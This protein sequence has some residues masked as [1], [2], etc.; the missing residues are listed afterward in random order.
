[1]HEKGFEIVIFSLDSSCDYQLVRK[2]LV[3]SRLKFDAFVSFKPECD[4]VIN[5]KTVELNGWEGILETL[6]R[7][8]KD[9]QKG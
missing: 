9:E 7:V 8:L 1:M 4:L 2:W 3:N 6:A 5:E